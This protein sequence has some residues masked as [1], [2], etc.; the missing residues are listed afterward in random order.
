MPEM[1]EPLYTADEA[2]AAEQGHDVGELMERAGAALARET[3]P[4]K[5][6]EKLHATHFLFSAGRISHE[7]QA[8]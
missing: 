6:S 8:V 1:L 2:R 5:C 7:Q 3:N 4:D